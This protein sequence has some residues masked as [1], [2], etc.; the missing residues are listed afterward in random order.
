MKIESSHGHL[1]EWPSVLLM[2]YLKIARANYMEEDGHPSSDTVPR[3]YPDWA[4]Q[5][6]T[7]SLKV[8]ANKFDTII[9]KKNKQINHLIFISAIKK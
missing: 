5:A 1:Q 3:S 7:I 4:C 8:S 2:V 9:E 6:V